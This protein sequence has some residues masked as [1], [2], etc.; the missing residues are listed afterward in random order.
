MLPRKWRVSESSYGKALEE[1]IK[2]TSEVY[3]SVTVGE[4]LQD[5]DGVLCWAY[6]AKV[7]FGKTRGWFFHKFNGNI[8]NGK[9]AAFNANELQTLKNA[10]HE[11]ADK[12][13]RMADEL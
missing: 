2:D 7:Y 5:L 12:I 11:V 10:L 6:F 13:H 9:V 8:V 4:K 1:L 3:H